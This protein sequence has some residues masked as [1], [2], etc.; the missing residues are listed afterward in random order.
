MTKR[1]KFGLLNLQ[2]AS[3]KAS[4]NDSPNEFLFFEHIQTRFQK[5]KGGRPSK[6]WGKGSRRAFVLWLIARELPLEER[7]KISNRKLIQ[8]AQKM[9]YKA[10]FSNCAFTTIEHSVARGKTTLEI[11]REWN[12]EVCKKLFEVI[13]KLQA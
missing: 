7:R 10:L 8:C 13:H 3:I 1:S 11:D 6:K 9:Q 5:N 2:Q 4:E 12:S